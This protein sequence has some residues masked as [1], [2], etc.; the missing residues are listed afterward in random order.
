MLMDIRDAHNHRHTRALTLRGALIHFDTHTPENMPTGTHKKMETSQF[1][2]NLAHVS[3][4]R[5]HVVMF[6]IRA[7]KLSS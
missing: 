2:T 3:R 7:E 1:T 6:S 5:L 4:N